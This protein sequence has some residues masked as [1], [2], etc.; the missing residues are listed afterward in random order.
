MS[1]FS[2]LVYFFRLGLTSFGGPLAIIAQIQRDLVDQRKV[3]SE[4]DFVRALS[5]IKSLP[6]PV[7]IQVVAFWSYR[8]CGAWIAVLASIL[9]VL[10]AFLMMLA[11]AIFYDQFR[12]SHGLV[13]LM[14]GMQAGAFVLILLALHS[15]SKSS[16][17]MPRFWVLFFLSLLTLGYFHVLE[18]VVIVAAG[19]ISIFWPRLTSGSSP[20]SSLR[21]FVLVDLF[22]VCLKA[23]AFTFGTGFAILPLLQADFV[24]LHHWVTQQQFMDA[25]AF[26]QLTPGPISVAVT[27]VGYRVAGFWGAL[28][29]TVAIYLP[30]VFNMTTWFP[31]TF[32]WFSRQGWVKPF[33]TGAT[34]A[35][36][37]GILLAL[38]TIAGVL[39]PGQ[40]VI[41]VVLLI[42]SFRFSIPSWA[43]VVVSGASWWLIQAIF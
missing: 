28:L 32:T 40:L 3:I 41:P 36:A 25:I 26:G 21:S 35:I 17:S 7:A 42:L 18:P 15:I 27:F 11:L 13:Q 33:V 16:Y 4:E 24:D 30:G 1:P 12:A 23:G 38:V 37:A 19:L 34:A 29:A 43:L 22:W 5:L 14:D 2:L 10:P 20:G 9:F 31:R 39:Q 6:G 8:L